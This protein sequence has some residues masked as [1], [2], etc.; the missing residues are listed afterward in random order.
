MKHEAL[1]TPIDLLTAKTIATEIGSDD[2][3]LHLLFCYVAAAFRQGYLFVKPMDPPLALICEEAPGDELEKALRDG[4]TKFQERSSA[5]PYLVYEKERL[6]VQRARK[7][8]G[9][10]QSLYQ[11]VQTVEPRLALTLEAIS[12]QLGHLQ[13]TNKLL[14]EQAQAILAAASST[15]SCIWGGPGTG[16]T[17]TAGWLAS[18]FLAQHPK[19]KIALAAPTGK[20]AANLKL[21][22][23]R[24][25]DP[26]LHG[27]FVAKTLHSLLGLRRFGQRQ[28]KEE[29]GF[30]LI[31]VDECSMIDIELMC[32]LFSQVAAGSRLVLLGDPHQLPP[33]EPG[34]PFCAIVQDKVQ[35][36]SPGFL[37]KTKRQEEGA[38]LQLAAAVREGRV[39]EALLLLQNDQANQI[40]WLG[41]ET[42]LTP[43]IEHVKSLYIRAPETINGQFAQLNRLRLL[44]PLRE[45]KEGSGAI[46][47]KIVRAMKGSSYEPIQIT[48]ND[49]QL[50]LT[51]G[52]VGL[53]QHELAYFEDPEEPSGYRAIPKILL[54]AYETA[55]CLSVHKSQ[56]SEFEEVVLFLPEG[57]ERFGRKMLY[58]AIT[59]AKKRFCLIGK[60]EILR[61][62]I[63]HDGRKVTTFFTLS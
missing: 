2:A 15:L 26:S 22:I 40:Q 44:C 41:D 12:Q 56:G 47:Q 36:K 21:S 19:A 8:L 14:A 59:R 43:T 38:I 60:Q 50:G 51:N 54:P 3:D 61:A 16:K 37:V 20:A 25:V 27:S 24:A 5:S 53:L 31:L 49:S 35:Q 10:L 32:K 29:L 46:N 48:K 62:C 33:V 11:Q 30:D 52:Q 17:Y 34:E 1:F 6:Y 28:R 58:T 13:E 7:V 45:G 55:Y 18:L 23:Q 42:A 57:S 4:F 39:D 63:A 9:T